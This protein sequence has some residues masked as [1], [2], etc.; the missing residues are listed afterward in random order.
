MPRVN[1][2]D[3]TQKLYEA[4]IDRG[5]LYPEDAEGVAWI[6]LVSFE[7]S[8]NGGSA[9]PYYIDGV[10]FLNLAGADEFEGTLNAFYSPPEFDECDGT[11]EITEGMYATQQFRKNFGFSYRTKIGNP[12][13]GLRHGYKINLIYNALALPTTRTYETVNADPS[14]EPIAWKITT[15]PVDIPNAK[16]GARIYIDSTRVDDFLLSYLEDILYGSRFANPRLPSP[17]EIYDIFTDDSLFI[18]TELDDGLYTLAGA[19]GVV[20][21]NTDGT[22]T[23]TSDSVTETSPGLF[24]IEY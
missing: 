7:D 4:G 16:P 18:V 12:Q 6:G 21:K 3:P 23:I 1:W 5:M 15:M 24:A 9:K 8:P 17:Q 14:A 22:A 13:Q 11:L 20:K 19:K 10:K 2:E